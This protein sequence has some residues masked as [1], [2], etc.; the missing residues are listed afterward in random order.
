MRALGPRTAPPPIGLPVGLADGGGGLLG[1]EAGVPQPDHQAGLPARQLQ[2]GLQRP[3]RH[4][5]R[6]GQADLRRP[7]LA[8][9]KGLLFL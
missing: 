8:C 9:S 1:S 5:G 7:G 4:R 2:P 3:H 6:L